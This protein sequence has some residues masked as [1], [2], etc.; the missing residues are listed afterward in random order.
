MVWLRVIALAVGMVAAAGCVPSV[1]PIYGQSD[2]LIDNELVGRWV[3]SEGKNI[4]EFSILDEDG[5]YRLTYIDE[6]GQ[7]A[8]FRACL[9]RFNDL[10][11]FDIYPEADKTAGNWYYRI[12]LF[13]VHTFAL[14]QSRKPNLEV[15]FINPEWLKERL[16]EEPGALAHVRVGD[17][18]LITATT[19]ELQRFV[20]GC[21]QRPRAFGKPIIW[22]RISEE[23]PPAL[24]SYEKL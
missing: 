2:L 9:A 10:D 15:A 14:V 16:R 13:P 4:L 12:H 17:A 18:V 23:I 6:K 7:S 19:L 21:A 5:Q 24:N 22:R 3:D 1:Y 20:A 8:N 11:M